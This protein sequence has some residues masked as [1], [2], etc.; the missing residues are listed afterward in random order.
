MKSLT[1]EQFEEFGKKRLKKIIESGEASTIIA[2]FVDY[3]GDSEL[4]LCSRCSTP[5]W[6]R[7][8]RLRRRG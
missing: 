2:G 1:T 5:V 8:S 4:T 3:F 7:I 6:V